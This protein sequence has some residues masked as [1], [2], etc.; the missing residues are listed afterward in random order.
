MESWENQDENIPNVCYD[1][2]LKYK[3]RIVEF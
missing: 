3:K 1:L 2:H